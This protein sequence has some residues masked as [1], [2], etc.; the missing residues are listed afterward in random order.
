LLEILIFSL[1]NHQP[2]TINHQ[3]S[4][5]NH[6]PSTISDPYSFSTYIEASILKANKFSVLIDNNIATRA[7]SLTQGNKLNESKSQ[8]ESYKIVSATMAYFILGGF[9]IEPN[10][11]I[12]EKA[13][14]SSHLCALAKLKA[15]RIADNITPQQF[16]RPVLRLVSLR[17]AIAISLNNPQR[18]TLLPTG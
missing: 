9:A 7:I 17:S 6:Q 11:A 12:Y 1:L 2:S 10:I 3:P 8:K 15:I 13:S 14:K 4:T 18:T 16:V 5:I